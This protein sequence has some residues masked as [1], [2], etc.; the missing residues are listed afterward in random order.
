MA[1]SGWLLPLP[2]ATRHG[3]E[4]EPLSVPDRPRVPAGRAA[5]PVPQRCVRTGPSRSLRGER[6]CCVSLKGL[7]S[8]FS[9]FRG[10]SAGILWI[11]CLFFVVNGRSDTLVSIY[12]FS[13]SPKS[14]V[15]FLITTNLIAFCSLMSFIS[16]P[17]LRQYGLSLLILLRRG[18]TAPSWSRLPTRA[19]VSCRPLCSRLMVLVAA[20]LL[21][22]P[23]GRVPFLTAA[24][25][26]ERRPALFGGSGSV[27]S[28]GQVWASLQSGPGASTEPP[29]SSPDSVQ[30]GDSWPR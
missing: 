9:D 4:Q 2:Q 15:M 25:D 16:E 30:F 20:S 6:G 1:G 27:G 12:I 13:G 17:P 26:G 29:M 14:A 21:E 3:R 22:A 8:S 23:R 11:M 5:Y 28:G 18:G 24:P 7:D 10:L 19:S